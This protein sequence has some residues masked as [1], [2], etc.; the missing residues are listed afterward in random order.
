MNV[1]A[2]HNNSYHQHIV[3]KLPALN[4]TMV[5]LIEASLVSHVKDWYT[6][7]YKN[8]SLVSHM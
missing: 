2:L 1:T 4:T 5:V 8:P 7:Q 6:T 3:Y